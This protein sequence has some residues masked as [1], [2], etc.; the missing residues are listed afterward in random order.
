V[1]FRSQVEVGHSNSVFNAIFPYIKEE[2]TKELFEAGLNEF[3]DLV[4]NYWDGVDHLLKKDQSA[5]QHGD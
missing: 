4:E 5:A 1:L 2:N 3:L